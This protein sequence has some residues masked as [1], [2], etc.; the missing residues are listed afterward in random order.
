MAELGTG[1][2]LGTGL[3]APVNWQQTGL[4]IDLIGGYTPPGAIDYSLIGSIGAPGVS[5]GVPL[6][7]LGTGLYWSAPGTG[8]Q[9]PNVGIQA[10]G[11]NLVFGK[12]YGGVG[13]AGGAGGTSKAGGTGGTG[14]AGTG[15]GWNV[16]TLGLGIQGLA[17]IGGLYN[18][19][20]YNKLAKEQ[21]NFTKEITN[22]NLNNQIK[23]FNTTMED[24]ARAR[25]R[26]DGREDTEAY[27]KDYMDKN[28]ISRG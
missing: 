3:R 10:L 11:N 27:T 1:T 22:T 24:R 9:A 28:R 8:L 13:G 20:K 16:E 25:A 7:A 2:I 17:A 12:N 23:T 18:A 4:P 14:G 19:S 15:L 6:G 26:L 21:F 5:T